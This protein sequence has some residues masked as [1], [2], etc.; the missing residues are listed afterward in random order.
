MERA[1]TY[2]RLGSIAI[3]M[4]ALILTMCGAA[5]ATSVTFTGNQGTLAASAMFDTSGGNLVVTLSNISTADCLVP[6]NLLSTVFF[7]IAE[8]PTLTKVSAV[9]AS[10]SH[11]YRGGAQVSDPAGGVVG[12]NWAYKNGIG[13]AP[14]GATYGIGSSGLG[15]F[16]NGDVF[17]GTDLGGDTGNP[18]DGMAYNLL[19]A[20]DNPS[21]GNSPLR[22][23][24]FIGNSVAFTLGGLPDGFDPS[25]AISKVYFQYGTALSEPGFRSETRDPPVPVSGDIPEPM[26][27]CGLCLGVLGLVRYVRRRAAA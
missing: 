3:A 21:T 5:Q 1:S 11:I 8:S 10:G 2:R 16:G 25:A 15:I 4:A 26:T 13:G 19:S 6:A 17:P 24:T 18:P 9:L 7:D 22:T 14:N 20:G 27:A 23:R 12:G